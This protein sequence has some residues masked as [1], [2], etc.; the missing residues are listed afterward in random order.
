MI[1]VFPMLTS[2]DVSPHVI[3]GISAVLEKFILIY[4]TD[5]ILKSL[6]KQR[7]IDVLRVKHRLVA[8]EEYQCSTHCQQ[9][10]HTGARTGVHD[11]EKQ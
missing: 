4:E 10:H 8:R 11:H 2:G 6:R 5:A 7:I 9:C 3:P 1:F